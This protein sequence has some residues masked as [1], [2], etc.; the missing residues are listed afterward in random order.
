[1]NEFLEA[2]KI[3]KNLGKDTYQSI[4]NILTESPFFYAQDDPVAFSSLRRN[5]KAFEEFFNKY[6][7]WRLY[8]DSRMARLVKDK[9]HNKSLNSAQ[10]SFFNLTTRIECI[11]FMFL[12]EF[13]EHQCHEQQFSYDDHQNLR[14]RYGD[15]FAFARKTLLDQL[16]KNAPSEKEV[17]IQARNLF[18]KLEQYRL[19]EIV[20]VQKIEGSTSDEL[21][22]EALPGLNCYE[23]GK[24]ME[25][26]IKQS[27]QTQKEDYDLETENE[28]SDE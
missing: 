17:D 16:E 23:G 6:F 8:V 28:E 7:G 27:Y 21:L 10:K 5:K 1:M 18:K 2:D 20:E 9:S 11:L 3:S 12:L 13:Y 24:I 15:Y 26:V 14:F 25:S 19:I 4:L 22:I